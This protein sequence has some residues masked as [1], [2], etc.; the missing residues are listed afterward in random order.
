M[1][2]IYQFKQSVDNDSLNKLTET[3][4]TFVYIL[5]MIQLKML[6]K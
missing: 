1:I 2:Q 5:T 6:V 4:N 3:A